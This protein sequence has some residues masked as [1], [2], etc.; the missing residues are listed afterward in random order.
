M[1]VHLRLQVTDFVSQPTDLLAVGCTF[2]LQPLA[3]GCLV[4][5]FGAPPCQLLV[6]S[7]QH[8]RVALQRGLDIPFMANEDGFGHRPRHQLL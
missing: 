3:L 8:G 7:K 5:H 6:G 2:F 4:C 1:M